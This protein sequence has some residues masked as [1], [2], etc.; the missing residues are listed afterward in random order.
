MKL[1]VNGEETPYAGD[2]CLAGLLEHMGLTD[3]NVAVVVNAQVVEQAAI[4]HHRLRDGDRV[5]VLTLAG[6]G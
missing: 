6:G 5:D 3:R 2:A 4:P 1:I